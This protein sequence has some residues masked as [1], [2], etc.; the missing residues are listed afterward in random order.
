MIYSNLKPIGKWSGPHFGCLLTLY[1][2]F[3]ALLFST[4]AI[5]KASYVTHFGVGV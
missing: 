1:N 2:F 5:S 4:Q 3:K